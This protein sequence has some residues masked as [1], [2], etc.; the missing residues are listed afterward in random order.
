MRGDR[1]AAWLTDR[2]LVRGA[3]AAVV[4]TLVVGCGFGDSALSVSNNTDSAWFVRSPFGDAYPDKVLIMRIEPH[5]EGIV[6]RWHGE[7]DF[8]IELLDLSCAVVGT[9]ESS[10]GQTYFVDSTPRV[11]GVQVAVEPFARNVEG[12]PL[13]V[14]DCGGYYLL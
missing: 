9:F 10:D 13:A 3:V 4:F 2:A 5:R 7:R 14:L 8:S 11:E 6:A 12:Q 1:R